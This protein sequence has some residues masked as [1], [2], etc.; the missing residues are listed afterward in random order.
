MEIPLHADSKNGTKHCSHLTGDCAN[1]TWN[2]DKTCHIREG[3]K[4][5]EMLG[6]WVYSKRNYGHW[7]QDRYMF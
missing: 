1:L 4:G 5:S 6:V 7:G 2:M 3:R